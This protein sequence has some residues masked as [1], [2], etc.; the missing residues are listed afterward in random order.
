MLEVHLASEGS[1]GL[2]GEKEKEMAKGD[3]EEG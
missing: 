2:K 1:G 3:G